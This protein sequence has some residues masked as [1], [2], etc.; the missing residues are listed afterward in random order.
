MSFINKFA[1]G[2]FAVLHPDMN[3]NTW[4]FFSGLLTSVQGI[5]KQIP[6][7]GD[8]RQIPPSFTAV[9]QFQYII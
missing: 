9:R 8:Q 3:F 5:L 7:K 2:K 6:Q 4:L 1:A